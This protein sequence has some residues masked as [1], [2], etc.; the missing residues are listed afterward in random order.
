MDRTPGL[1]K[2]KT[3]NGSI[4]VELGK[5]EN[6]ITLLTSNGSIKIYLDPSI[7][8]DI[9]ASTSNSSIKLYDVEVTTRKFS[10]NYLVGSIGKGGKLITADTS[11]G[12][13][14]LYK[15]EK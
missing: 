1:E 11:N 8:A 9:K 4:K 13:I 2:V 12:R 7:N 6:D 15:L 10:N 3:S 5:M 14:S